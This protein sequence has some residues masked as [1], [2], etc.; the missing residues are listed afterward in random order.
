MFLSSLFTATSPTR[1]LHQLDKRLCF[2]V[3]HLI[4]VTMMKLP[5]FFSKTSMF[6][7][8]YKELYNDEPSVDG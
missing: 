5:L 2:R 7:D 4:R 8:I 3:L 1:Q 6:N